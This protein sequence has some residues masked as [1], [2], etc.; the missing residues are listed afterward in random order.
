MIKDRNAG[1]QTRLCALLCVLVMMF[2][3]FSVPAYAAGKSYIKLKTGSVALRGTAGT[4]G[5]KLA[6]LQQGW[7]MEKTGTVTGSD[8]KLW[9]AVS[10]YTPSDLNNIRSGFV[11]S[12]YVADITEAE[13]EAWYESKLG[14]K[15]TAAPKTYSDWGECKGDGVKLRSEADQSSAVLCQ[16]QRGAEF[17]ILNVPS[18][19]ENGWYRV[20]YQEYT[21]YISAAYVNRLTVEEAVSRGLIDAPTPTPSPAPGQMRGYIRFTHGTVALRKQPGLSSDVLYS[22]STGTEASWF[23]K[24][25][26]KVDGYYWY[27]CEVKGMRGW[28][29][30]SL[31]E[32]IGADEPTPVPTAVK[33]PTL[34]PRATATPVPTDAPVTG[35]YLKVKTGNVSLR[36]KAGISAKKLDTLKINEIMPWFT[37]TAQ[38]IDGHYWYEVDHNGTRGWVAADYVTEV[39][40]TPAPTATV[41]PTATPKPTDAPV[42]TATPAPTDTPVY[43]KYLKLKTGN[44]SLRAKAGTSGKKLD[45]LKI[46]EIV[47]W[48]TKTA[49]KIDGYYWYEVEHNGIRGWVAADYVTEIHDV[50]P[51]PVTA[52]PVITPRPTDAPVTV[53]GYVALTGSAVYVRAANSKE[54]A[55]VVSLKKNTVLELI[56]DPVADADGT[57]NVWYPVRT[58]DG[59]TG[60]V[61]SDVSY[62][63][64]EWQAEQYRKTGILCTPTP[65]PT[66][67]PSGYSNYVRVKVSKCN[68]RAS[69]STG[70][71]SLGTAVNGQ[72]FEFT[73]TQDVGNYTWYKVKLPSSFTS[74]TGWI[75]ADMVS[76]MT[77]DE[78]SEW[79]KQ[80]PDPTPSP[81]PTVTPHPDF[82]PEQMSDLG[83]SLVNNAT[84]RSGASVKSQSISKVVNVDSKVIVLGKYQ[85]DEEKPKLIWFE[86]QYENT[87]GWMRSDVLRVLTKREKLAYTQSGNP[88]LPPEA[89][90]T[91]LKQNDSGE[92]VLELQKELCRQGYLAESE[93]DG[94]YRG[95]TASAVENYQ[96]DHR[97]TVDG[98]AGEE[99]QHSLF[100]TVPVGTYKHSTA[101][102]DLQPVEKAD[103]FSVVQY[104]WERNEI[105][106]VTDVETGCSFRA[107]R[108]AGGQH[109]DVEPYSAADTAVMCHIYKV[110]DSQEILEKNLYQRR[111]LWVTIDGR[112]FAASMYGVPH[113]YP[114]GD[115]IPDNDFSGQFCIHFLNSKT[116]GTT[117]SPAHVDKDH[118]D[119][120]Q[121][122]Y[123]HSISG[124]K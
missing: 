104:V 5:E 71:A 89:S 117:A 110:A 122:A 124:K 53:V 75:R 87:T 15:R 90:Y 19:R 18:D 46:N 121:Y 63:L 113:N 7:V 111:A 20:Q 98:I 27:E 112:T 103:W 32:E 8:G 102:P 52:T 101:D 30:A 116:H 66:A 84:I 37:K 6:T 41:R 56:G 74:S 13:A 11:R 28:V 3:L 123:D 34:T 1:R 68:A 45:T 10:G 59:K 96:R 83:L 55:S 67:V 42:P 16:L 22:V 50:T 54:S 119:K 65:A 69:A 4:D 94:T 48:F 100:N 86:V 79:R 31:V 23:S 109:A 44:V 120:I 43:E 61:R 47:P 78:Y 49:V 115:T 26:Y 97:L 35:K 58:P 91:L 14:P 80:H 2:T 64:S 73:Q 107:R 60:Y 39:N 21:G 40:A 29:A 51:A 72:V 105:A 118:Q 24:T 17:Y 9:V 108:W 57:K 88:D 36:A 81:V 106:I 99:T 25:D 95:T 12:D 82:D 70:S 38:K 33:T 114:E 85:A 77:W 93:C 92:A 76:R 62:Q